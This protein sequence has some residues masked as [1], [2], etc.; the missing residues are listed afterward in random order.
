[1]INVC[2]RHRRSRAR[3]P[4]IEIQSHADIV[5][6]FIMKPLPTRP[7]CVIKPFPSIGIL[8]HI[9][10]LSTH[11]ESFETEVGVFA[12]DRNRNATRE[13]DT[14]PPRAKKNIPV[15]KHAERIIVTSEKRIVPQLTVQIIQII[16]MITAF[17]F[18][19]RVDK[20][21]CSM[22]TLPRFSF[23]VT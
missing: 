1:V 14:I 16:Q 17:F 4:V 18:A 10:F 20:L 7:S 15:I 19:T 21:L 23:F 11:P 2:N 12:R 5:W 3:L 22:K 8:R 13:P 9:F 6:S